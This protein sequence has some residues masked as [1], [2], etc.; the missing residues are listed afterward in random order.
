MKYPH[1]Q[2]GFTA[3]ELLITLFVAAAFLVAGYQLFSL[4]IRDGGQTRSESR[5]ANVAYDYLR[6]YAAS[7]TT[8]P[9]V[10]STPLTKAPIT[11]DGLVNAR[12]SITVSCLPSTSASLSK[13]EATIFFNVPEQT[14]KYATYTN[15][16]GTSATN[17]VTSG[18]VGWYKMNGD[19]N[20]SSVNGNNGTVTGATPTTGATNAANTA[21]AFASGG[22]YITVN[23][24][25]SS[26]G[27]NMTISAWVRPTVYPTDKKTIVE[28]INPLS[29]YVSLANDGSLASYR[30]GT[31]PSV[32]HATTAGA[33]PLNQWTFVTVAWDTSSVTLYINGT[34]RTSDATTGTGISGA[35]MT[36]GLE[37]TNANRQFIGSIDDVRIY[38]RTL[39]TADIAKLNAAGAQ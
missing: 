17:D 23:S 24:P 21:Y 16:S 12:I 29:Y 37:T 1:K 15:S 30:Y 8:V 9:C 34:L 22:Q 10:G 2:S 38:N 19:A 4:V 6:K 35:Q 33:I 27:Q 36:I 18:I 7:S 5:A 31:N 25:S 28:G 32:Y 14:V 13:V 3:V 20:D 11:V 26:L 39:S